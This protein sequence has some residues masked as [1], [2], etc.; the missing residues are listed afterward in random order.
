MNEWK[1]K[2]ELIFFNFFKRVEERVILLME[3]W[4]FFLFLPGPNDRIYHK[5]IYSYSCTYLRL[6]SFSG[7][8]LSVYNS[9]QLIP[10]LPA[11]RVGPS[12]TTTTNFPLGFLFFGSVYPLYNCN[13]TYSLSRKLYCINLKHSYSS[14][15]KHPR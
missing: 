13:H 6:Y 3:M 2:N 12:Q 8:K 5:D 11:C 10:L 9:D 14:P 1:Y 7:A 4:F 15:M